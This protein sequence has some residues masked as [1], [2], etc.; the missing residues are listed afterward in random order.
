M[1]LESPLGMD[2]KVNN[3]ALL[4]SLSC[5]Q[6][7]DVHTRPSQQNMRTHIHVVTLSPGF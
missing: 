6:N 7:S 3:L 1:N 5:L 4:D 2:M